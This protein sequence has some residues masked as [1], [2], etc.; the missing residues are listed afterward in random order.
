MHHHIVALDAWHVPI[1]STLFDLPAPTSYTLE[2]C[3]SRLERPAQIYHAIKNASIIAVTVS[4]L[5]ATA[6]SESTTPNLKLVV[7]V[8]AGTDGIDLVKCRERGIRVLNSPSSNAQSV[9]EHAVAL[10][11]A[12]RRRLIT[13]QHAMLDTPEWL[14]NGTLAHKMN[15]AGSRL[16]LSCQEEVVGVVGHGAVG[17]LRAPLHS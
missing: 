4:P 11:F 8:A 7:A 10:Y 6:L 15:I 5:D 17:K 14:T 9:A 2:T 13:L 16:P 12:A 1:P 3:P